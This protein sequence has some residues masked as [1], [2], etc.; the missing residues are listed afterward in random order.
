MPLTEADEQ[1]VRAS[2]SLRR[3]KKGEA[4]QRAGDIATHGF[5]V[6]AGCL[7]S[8][9]IDEKGREHVLRFAP[10]GWWL[11]DFK[12]M[13]DQEPSTY[14]VDALEASEVVAMPGEAHPRFLEAIPGYAAAFAAGLLKMH[15]A[16]ER[17]LLESMS[18]TAEQRYLSFLE[19][20]PSIARRVPQHM[21]ASYLGITPE[22]LSRL[23]AQLA[24]AKQVRPG[25][26]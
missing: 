8:Y 18:A 11:T 13:R 4:L 6:A 26:R 20:Y 2:V 9:S 23:R 24:R 21:L 1:L 7:R 3:V 22:T 19:T 16:R 25:A 17:R 15:E 10:E 5:F 12:S 14:F